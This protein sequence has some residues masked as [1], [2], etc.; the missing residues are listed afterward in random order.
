MFAEIFFSIISLGII[1][2]YIGEYFAATSKSS[3]EGFEEVHCSLKSS[4]IIVR[5][6]SC[7][8]EK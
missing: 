6:S 4:L 3:T 7:F 5:I 1:L 8:V 2:S